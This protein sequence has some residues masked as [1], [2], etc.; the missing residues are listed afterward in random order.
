VSGANSTTSHGSAAMVL[1]FAPLTP[2]YAGF[3]AKL[4]NFL[5]KWQK[6]S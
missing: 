4:A 3:F 6:I 1:E 5:P 2:T